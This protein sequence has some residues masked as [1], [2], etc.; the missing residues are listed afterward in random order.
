[1][2]S[3]VDSLPKTLC[4]TLLVGGLV[5]CVSYNERTAH[6]LQDFRTGDFPGAIAEFSQSDVTGSEF[7]SGAEAGTVALT[8]GDWSG[9]VEHLT[10]AADAS[11]DIEDT[12]L[13]DP[14][15][16]GE[17][18]VSWVVNETFSSYYGEGYERACLHACLGLAYLGQGSVE[19]LLVEVRRA[20]KL[21]KAEESLYDTDYQAGGLAHFLS[22][23]GYELLGE[24]D[25]AYI[26]Y[27][28][29]E[30]K[31][32]G[33]ALVSKSLL[34]IA[35]MLH[36]DEDLK[37]WRRRWGEPDAYPEGACPIVLIGGIGLGPHKEELRLEVPTGD[38][39]LV[40]AVPKFTHEVQ[41]VTGLRLHAGGLSIDSVV[42]EDVGS[43]AEQNL[44]DRIAFL[45]AKSAVRS[46]LKMELTKS[47]TEKHGDLGWLAGNL[48]ALATER[49][50]LRAWSTLPNQWHAARAF[51]A[52]GEVEI[53]LDA[54]GGEHLSLG[55]YHLEPGETVFVLARTVGPFL[56]AHVIGGELLLDPSG[57]PV[58]VEVGEAILQPV[59]S[60]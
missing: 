11:R 58:D 35:N 38:G 33:G 14:G 54:Q 41:T 57:L 59:A 47:L 24:P 30:A 40:W 5:S 29:L 56:Y 9:A 52:P 32:L 3:P 10:R 23:V 36:R 21:L 25:N 19:D 28:A 13:L 27:R 53:T 20:N 55:R 34:R 17:E 26:D 1:V 50:D 44:S 16:V 39:L 7:L 46:V 4:I 8:A 37:E 15:A 48:F 60:E 51:V 31:G 22:A 18:L 45:A 49:A 43:V 12:A 6:A 42:V 2:T